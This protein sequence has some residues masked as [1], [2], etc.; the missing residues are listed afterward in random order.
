LQIIKNPNQFI[1]YLD[2]IKFIQ[3]KG[4]YPTIVC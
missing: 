2:N 3:S 4:I 1:Q